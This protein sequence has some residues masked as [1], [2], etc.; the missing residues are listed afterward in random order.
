[1]PVHNLFKEG[2]SNNEVLMP[3]LADTGR[4]RYSEGA[5]TLLN[6]AKEDDLCTP[7]RKLFMLTVNAFHRV[8]LATQ[9][10]WSPIEHDV[11]N[12]ALQ[13]SFFDTRNRKLKFSPKFVGKPANLKPDLALMLY[14]NKD[15]NKK[16]TSVYWKDVKVPILVKRN[17]R[18]EGE[19][20]VQMSGYAETIFMEQFD[21]KCVITVSLNATHCRLFHWDSVSCHV[22]ELIDIHKNPI[23]V[24]RCITRLVM[25]TP[26]ELGYD[27]HF[28][29]AGRLPSDEEVTTTLI[30]RESPIQQYLNR[31]LCS[32]EMLVPSEMAR[33]MLLELDTENFLSESKL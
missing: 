20:I 12:G 26:A 27:E 24:I 31:E 29:N 6:E 9:P 16:Q 30:V 28:S 17:F 32:E 2:S 4:P 11:I 1:R 15:A 21:R 25:M 14:H 7:F 18:S 10:P 13:R 3:I 19:I 33:S 5:F 22:T 8:S 23:L